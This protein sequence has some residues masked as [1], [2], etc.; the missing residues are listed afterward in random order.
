MSL[1]ALI[2]SKKDKLISLRFELR[3][4][5]VLTIHVRPRGGLAIVSTLIITK[6]QLTDVIT[7]YTRKPLITYSKN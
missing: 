5:S 3:T 1:N 6:C 2:R 7:N 4:F